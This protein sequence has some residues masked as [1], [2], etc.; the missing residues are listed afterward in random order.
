MTWLLWI[1]AA[2]LLLATSVMLV[3]VLL[4]VVPSRR[5]ATSV[6]TGA[7]VRIVVLV[8]AHDEAAG[9]AAVVAPLADEVDLLVVADNCTDDT[10]GVARAAGA[11]V[12]ER[13]DPV[14]RGK[15][16][17]LARGRD[18]LAA[19]PPDC[20]VVLDADTAID[21]EGV[22]RLAAEAVARNRPVQGCY[23]LE[24]RS[25]ASVATRFSAAAFLVKNLVRQL[26]TRR[27]GAPALLVGSGM[28]FPWSQFAA[29]PLAT[30]HVA[31]DMMLGV[32]SAIEGHPPHFAPDVLIVGTTSSDTGTVT[33]R[34]RWESGA[35]ATARE[36]A[37]TLIRAAF[38]QRRL[39]LLWLALDLCVP[40][41]ILLLLLDAV[42][43]CLL[44]GAALFGAAT[45]PFIFLA[46]LTTALVLA[47][48]FSILSHGRADLVS[49]WREIP[50]YAL[51]KAKLSLGVLARRERDWI[52]TERD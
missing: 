49:G 39:G 19:D 43:L 45:A 27:L 3:E 32:V 13:A 21:A 4:G 24:P 17:A 16:F 6:A 8:P 30:G 22:R 11:R 20:V 23:L 41:L 7:P 51:W 42:L 28:A 50:R 52:R 26:G 31:E 15:G 36:F 40:P 25:D 12:V 38:T 10:A 2:P 9:I 34:R 18:E 46:I 48:P 37:P 14:H 35:Q 5:R 33:Q 29:L 47:V 1:L 44:L